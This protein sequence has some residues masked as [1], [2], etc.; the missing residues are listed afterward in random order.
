M[1]KLTNLPNLLKAEAIC[2]NDQD[3]ISN[4]KI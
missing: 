2:G 1:N 4:F 3:N